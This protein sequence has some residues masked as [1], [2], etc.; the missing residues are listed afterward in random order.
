MSSERPRYRL[1]CSCGCQYWTKNENYIWV[2][3]ECLKPMEEQDA[4]AIPKISG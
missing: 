3:S 2:C 1:T 4:K